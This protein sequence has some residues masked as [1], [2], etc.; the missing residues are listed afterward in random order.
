M[1]DER[2]ESDALIEARFR[3]FRRTN[4]VLICIL[5]AL[6]VPM[7]LPYD[8]YTGHQRL[9]VLPNGDTL[10]W[11]DLHDLEAAHF[12]YEYS[13]Y[14]VEPVSPNGTTIRLPVT[15]MVR[16]FR[17][18]ERLFGQGVVSRQVSESIY[19]AE[20]EVVIVEDEIGHI[21]FSSYRRAEAVPVKQGECEGEG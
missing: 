7:M 21:D 9:Y 2:I 18:R 12:I 19:V 11:G 16:G 15:M 5:L 3:R 8:Q 1:A 10:T 20:L 6:A 17:S 14:T 4:I 13:R